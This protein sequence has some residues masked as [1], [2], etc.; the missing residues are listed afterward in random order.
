MLPL[1]LAL[2]LAASAPPPQSLHY[3]D[4]VAAARGADAVAVFEGLPRGQPPAAAHFNIQDQAFFPPP[5]DF[6]AR[7]LAGVDDAVL[8]HRSNFAPWSGPKFCGGFHADRAVVW[9]QGGQVR[10]RALFCFGCHEARFI[11]G[12]R[13]EWVDMS[14]GGYAVLRHLLLSGPLAYRPVPPQIPPP[15][16]NP[17]GEPK[18][19][20]V[21]D[22]QIWP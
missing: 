15:P 11:V 12:S 9:C 10:A 7:E 16:H 18:L 8:G 5:L 14:D 13:T 21:P 17:I 22:L 4:F 2:P 20:A 3:A 6:S 1:F 19:P